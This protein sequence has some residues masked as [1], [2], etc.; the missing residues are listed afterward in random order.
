MVLAIGRGGRCAQIERCLLRG[1]HQTRAL[2][3]ADNTATATASSDVA[4]EIVLRVQR[5][6]QRSLL[7]LLVLQRVGGECGQWRE[8]MGGAAVTQLR[9]Q[10]DHQCA[11]A[12]TGIRQMFCRRVNQ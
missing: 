3:L 7:L 5:G 11:R 9:P 6:K 2:A 12:S 10:R 1:A 8:R 4:V